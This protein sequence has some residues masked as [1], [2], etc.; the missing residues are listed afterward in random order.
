MDYERDFMKV[1]PTGVPLESGVML[2]ST[3]FFNDTFF[4]HSV[5][6]LLETGKEGSVGLI[7][8]KRTGVNVTDVKP[9]WKVPDQ[10]DVGG[11]VMLDTIITLH[12]FEDLD[13]F[14]LVMPG[15][16]SGIDSV[17]LSLI[18]HQAIST[19]KYRFF[20]GYS[21]WSGGQLES[22]LQR[23]MWVISPYLPTL[24]FDTPVEKIW[25]SA[26]KNLGSDYS[27]WLDIQEN[28]AFN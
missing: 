7:L 20:L 27:H 9:S 16:Y 26:V 25:H 8:N 13:R 15:L 19:L 3:P 12:N 2:I 5:V 11:P 14:R 28:I 23:N 18:E 24:V 17:L 21:G 10:F 4:N 1:K 22:E 6:L